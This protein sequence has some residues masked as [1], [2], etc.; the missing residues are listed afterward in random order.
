[1]LKAEGKIGGEQM[2][3]YYGYYSNKARGMRQ[4]A[5]CG[6]DTPALVQS[7][8]SSTAWRKNW[9]RLI[10]K[11]YEVEPLLCPKYHFAHRHMSM[12]D[13]IQ[14]AVWG[15]ALTYNRAFD[16]VAFK[17]SKFLSFIFAGI[18][19]AIGADLDQDTKSI[20]EF[21]LVIVIDNPTGMR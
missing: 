5:D 12:P 2:V 8:L 4:K 9:A 17:K 3:R 6:D 15:R 19:F 11:R 7:P 13:P 16:I 21:G 10:Q 20:A 18:E 1:M 14:H